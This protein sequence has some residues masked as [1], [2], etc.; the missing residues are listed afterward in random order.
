VIR[1]WDVRNVRTDK[2]VSR[3]A[4]LK[5]LVTSMFNRASTDAI[6]ALIPTE[7]AGG[8]ALG[9]QGIRLKRYVAA[10]QAGV[11]QIYQGDTEADVQQAIESLLLH[12]CV[13]NCDDALRRD[14]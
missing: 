11:W 10:D 3:S 7:I 9:A 1:T 5:Y 6:L 12:P 8:K 13:A 14:R 2:Q 4:T